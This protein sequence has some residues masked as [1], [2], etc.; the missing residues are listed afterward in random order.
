[1]T[2]EQDKSAGRLTPV[3]LCGGAG[4]RLWPSSRLDAP[5]P[6]LRLLDDRTLFDGTVQRVCVPELFAPPVIIAHRDHRHFIAAGTRRQGCRAQMLLE[7]EGYDTAAAVAVACALAARRDPETLLLVLASDH[8]V[9]DHAAF[10]Q[11]ARRAAALARDGRIVVFGIRPDHPETRYGY[12]RPGAALGEGTAEVREFVEKPDADAAA[13]YVASG[14]RWN[15]GNVVMQ[16]GTGLAEI[17]RIW[18]ALAEAAATIAAGV[19]D[20]AGYADLDYACLSGMEKV[21]FDRAVLEKTD[22]AAMVEARYDWSDAGSWSSLWSLSRQDSDGNVAVG[23]VAMTNVRDSFI[24]SEGRLVGAVG[25]E[26]LIIVADDDAVL[27]T[28]RDNSEAVKDLVALLKATGRGQVRQTATV[29]RPWGRFEVLATGP[30]YQIKR[31]SVA[32]GKR[33]S[34]QKH[35]RRSEQWT[36]ARGRAHVTVEGADSVLEPGQSITIGAGA[37]HRL[38]NRGPG[39]LEIIEIQFGDYL[40]EDD[41]AR[42]EDDHARAP[43]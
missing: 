24:R 19:A 21:S 33:L 27:V 22:R 7:P 39:P 31:I 20:G 38:E 28:S 1:M 42:I 36:V 18:P 30:G 8:V 40:G 9:R 32:A 14:Y 17:A 23:D 43:G 13:R 6:F 5:K 29:D 2:T 35:M 12:I 34:L 10:H 26:N 15:S 41:I 16:A 37:V 11:D 3:I 4:S 25:V